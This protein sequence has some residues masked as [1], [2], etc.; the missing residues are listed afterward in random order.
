MLLH[1]TLPKSK[2]LPCHI[3]ICLDFRALW[4]S[5]GNKSSHAAVGDTLRRCTGQTGC[6]ARTDCRKASIRQRMR[7]EPP[8]WPRAT[9]PGPG[10]EQDIGSKGERLLASV[11]LSM[12][13]SG[14]EVLHGRHHVLPR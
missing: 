3:S 14:E 2:Q 9:V 12:L 13:V 8:Y 10:L 1:H 7:H 6:R 5:M 11:V 4:E